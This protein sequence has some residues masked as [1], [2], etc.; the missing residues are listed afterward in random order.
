MDNPIKIEGKVFPKEFYLGMKMMLEHHNPSEMP[1]EPPS[2][3]NEFEDR[4]GELSFHLEGLICPIETM[5]EI[6]GYLKNYNIRANLVEVNDF[7]HDKPNEI[8]SLENRIEILLNE[9]LEQE[10][11]RGY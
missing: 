11:Y 9:I 7:F 1:C 4:L 6:D 3:L 2:N 5:N 10:I 8:N